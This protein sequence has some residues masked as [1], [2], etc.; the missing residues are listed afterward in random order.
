MVRREIRLHFSRV[1]ITIE[2]KGGWVRERGGSDQGQRTKALKQR[3]AAEQCLREI[4]WIER[5]GEEL[6]KD[7]FLEN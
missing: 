3:W 6:R 4:R 7:S 1:V 2:R 5:R